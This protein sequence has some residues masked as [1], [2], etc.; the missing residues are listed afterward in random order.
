MREFRCPDC[1]K[2]IFK[3]RLESGSVVEIPCPRNCGLLRFTVQPN[4]AF[5]ESDGAGGFILNQESGDSELP[6]GLTRVSAELVQLIPR[7]TKKRS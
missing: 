2:L 1:N 5:L 3:G 6:P 4:R 7:A